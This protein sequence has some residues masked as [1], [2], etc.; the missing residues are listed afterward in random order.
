MNQSNEMA[1]LVYQALDDKKAAD[2]HM[3]N[4]SEISVLGDYF[5]IAGGENRNQVQAMSDNV[6]EYLGRAG[7]ECK[8][9]EGYQTAD[10]ILQDYGDV[11]VHI[12]N[13]EARRFYDLERIWRDGKM[14]SPEEL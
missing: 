1:K 7:Y 8:N 9:V 6:S 10:W 3:I 13:K 12:F 5:I 2:I 4:I 14:V 11:V